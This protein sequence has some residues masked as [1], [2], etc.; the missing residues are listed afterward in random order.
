ML[1]NLTNKLA[2]LEVGLNLF[3]KRTF[4]RVLVRSLLRRQHDVDTGG[5]TGEDLCTQ[6]LLVQVNSGA[7]D[8]VEQEGGDHTVDLEGE[9]GRLDD[10]Q[11]ANQGVNDYRQ[12]VAVVNGNGVGLAVDLDDRLAT[13][14]DEDGVVLLGGNLDDFTWV[15]I[16]LNKP[17]VALEIPTRRLATPH[18]LRLGLLIRY[19]GSRTRHTVLRARTLPWDSRAATEV[20]ILVGHL[21]LVNLA[22]A[23]SNRISLVQLI[24]D[25]SHVRR[26]RAWLWSKC[27]RRGG[28]RGRSTTRHIERRH[29]RRRRRR[30]ANSASQSALD[31]FQS[32]LRIE[33]SLVI[34]GQAIGIM[35]L[36]IGSE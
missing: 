14:G 6:T 16:M 31:L 28:R 32:F 13:P 23:G 35:F 8:L 2:I 24:K 36:E 25:C 21:R 11:T 7:V 15:V 30:A 17:L 20:G 3:R 27:T 34:P 22:E 18:A 1:N 5:L 29:G 19:R 9:L 10:V 4:F 12:A 33:A 26:G